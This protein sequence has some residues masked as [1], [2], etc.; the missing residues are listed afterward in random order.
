[1]QVTSC[2]VVVFCLVS[3]I[4]KI[5]SATDLNDSVLVFNCPQQFRQLMAQQVCLDPQTYHCL[6]VR[7]NFKQVQFLQTCKYSR[8]PVPKGEYPIQDKNSGNLNSE[9]CPGDEFQ[10]EPSW[11]N[12]QSRCLFRKSSCNEEGQ[13]VYSDENSSRDR[14][15]VCD[16]TNGY[17]FTTYPINRHYCVPFEEDCSCYRDI[18]LD[19]SY[20]TDIMIV[21][22]CLNYLD[23]S[24]EPTKCYPVVYSL[25][26]YKKMTQESQKITSKH[27]I[28]DGQTY[29]KQR[30]RYIGLPKT[31]IVICI[32]CF[33]LLTVSFKWNNECTTPMWLR[34]MFCFEQGCSKHM[35]IKVDIN[36]TQADGSHTMTIN[37]EQ[38]NDSIFESDPARRM[39]TRVVS[40]EIFPSKPTDE[41]D[42]NRNKHNAESSKILVP[43][44]VENDEKCLES[45][46]SKDIHGA[47]YTKSPVRDITVMS[48]ECDNS[49]GS[50]VQHLELL[51]RKYEA[52]ATIEIF[53]ENA[54]KEKQEII[55]RSSRHI[56][57]YITANFTIQKFKQVVDFEYLKRKYFADPINI[58]RVKLIYDN[59]DNIPEELKALNSIPYYTAGN[60]EIYNNRMQYYFV[61]R[62]N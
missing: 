39:G 13:I 18:K 60:S 35:P 57:I 5:N 10:F 44:G 30:K 32:I 52:G 3:Y 54:P 50:Y 11:S 28:Q 38:P 62:K 24:D 25:Y 34:K 19:D 58:D 41:N 31:I 6:R 8:T 7:S 17:K 1:M 55:L 9:N 40:A 45:N 22:A 36:E 16:Y 15:C 20:T 49:V 56:F 48:V 47:E 2:C 33:L 46:D 42:V 51:N 59:A 27:E 12:E 61:V 4:E 43:R 26:K 53:P 37:E 21:N 23:M 29:E 14:R